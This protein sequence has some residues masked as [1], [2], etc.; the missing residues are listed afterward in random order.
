M[1]DAV[2]DPTPVPMVQY[3]DAQLKTLAGVLGGLVTSIYSL[4]TGNLLALV[5]VAQAVGTLKGVDWAAALAELSGVGDAAER[6]DIESA[7]VAAL[8]LPQPL[9]SQILQGEG[10]LEQIFSIADEVYELYQSGVG[11]YQQT[12]ALI[13]QIRT[14]LGV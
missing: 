9:Q 1:T 6:A 4:V 8:A 12:V 10:Y 14:F 3:D 11:I 7:F 5:A 13:A 2:K